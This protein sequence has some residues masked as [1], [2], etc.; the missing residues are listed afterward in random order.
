MNTTA[1]T[2]PAVHA[3]LC[4]LLLLAF[5]S[6][7][8]WSL[9]LADGR[10]K[11]VLYEAT[12][13]FGLSGQTRGDPGTFVPLLAAQDPR[14]TMVSVVVGNKTYRMGE[15]SEFTAKAEKTPTGGRFIWSSSFL[16]VTETFTFIASSGSPVTNG[17][18]IDLTLKNVSEQG[19]KAGA[20]YLFDTYL[21]ESSFVQFRTDSLTQVPHELSLTPEDQTAYWLSPLAGDAD[22]FGLE[23]MTSGPGITVPD[24]IVFAN[25]KRLS[26]STWSFDSS[27]SRNFSVPPYS[28]ND[29]AA[30]QYYNPR[31]LPRGGELTF[32]LALGIYS[33][34]GFTA[35][36]GQPTAFTDDLQ[37]SLSAAKAASDTDAAVRADLATVNRILAQIDKALA[38]GAS[39]TDE[40]LSAMESALKDLTSRVSGYDAAAA[41]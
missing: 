3:L 13:R 5:A 26:D 40:E 12:G 1:R 4:S 2:R 29:S 16:Q 34:S 21:G 36:T 7:R 22:E 15:S 10:I 30:C 18:Q 11:L 17:I 41:K 33:R 27:P 8:L 39:L 9:D 19:M 6:P 38:S 14:T 28:V 20:R 37:K 25:W 32:T 35:Q 23:V 31:T 24:R